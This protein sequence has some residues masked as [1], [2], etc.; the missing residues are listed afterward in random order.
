MIDIWLIVLTIICGV[1][2]IGINIYLFVLYSHPDDNKDV[3]GWIGR[4]V[5]LGGS[6]LTWALVLLLPLDVANSRGIGGGFNMELF[7]QIMLLAHFIFLIVLIPITI[8]LYESDDE[9]PFIARL[10]RAFCYDI[11]LIIVVIILSIIAWSAMKE[12]NYVD[13]YAS[14][15]TNFMTSS[16]DLVETNNQYLVMNFK[17]TI[18]GYLFVVVFWIFVGWFLFVMFGGVGIIALPLDLIL[19]YFYR[20]KP[21]SAREMAEKKVVLRRRVEELMTY[22]Q[23]IEMTSEENKEKTGLFTKWKGDRNLKN[24]ENKLRRELFKLEEE[25]E[26]FVMESNLSANPIL[27][28]LKLLLGCLF[29]IISF[30]ILIHI[31]FYKLIIID[32]I[33]KSEFLND[34]F[35]FLEFKI[36]RFVSTIFLAAFAIYVLFFVLKGNIK[37]GLRILLCIPIHTMKVGRTFIN[38]FL[39]N[40]MLVMVCTPAI[41]H[42]VIELLEAYMRLS[43]GAFIFTFLVKNMKF[44]RWFYEYKVF[45][46]AFLVFSLLTFIYLMCKPKNDR[47]NIK[48]M[49]EERKKKALN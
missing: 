41:L 32:G 7:Y 16:Q 30:M 25:Y 49:I 45:Y 36:A 47:L 17:Y 37:F 2:M 1:M 11:F 10:C 4:I 5:V 34:F 21:R 33:P 40:L 3:V 18:P 14:S 43:S 42:F 28:I 19:D 15:Y 44:F 13:L 12:A 48:N 8:F 39:F 24:K 27:A 26:I 31:V 23:T 22:I 9:R 29:M 38:G 35:V 46:Y 20:P 6:C